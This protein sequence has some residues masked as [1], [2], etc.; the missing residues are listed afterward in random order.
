[1]PM[2]GRPEVALACGGRKA[3]VL[4]C[5]RW[6]RGPDG[7]VR[8]GSVRRRGYIARRTS[9]SRERRVL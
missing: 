2:K 5:R 6:E 4:A 9:G 8:P 1:M 7:G 3:T